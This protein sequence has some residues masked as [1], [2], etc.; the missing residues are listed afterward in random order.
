MLFNGQ[1]VTL[2]M[3]MTVIIKARIVSLLLANSMRC[4]PPPTSLSLQQILNLGY[5]GDSDMTLHMQE[6][7]FCRQIYLQGDSRVVVPERWIGSYSIPAGG[8]SSPATAVQLGR[9]VV[10]CGVYRLQKSEVGM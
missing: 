10:W 7:G 6:Q 5:G 3:A 2:V 9:D 1:S 8:A 4:L